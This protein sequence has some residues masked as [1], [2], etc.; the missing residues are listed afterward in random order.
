[1][2]KTCFFLQRNIYLYR[3]K[4]FDNNRLLLRYIFI[5][6]AVVIAIGSLIISHYFVADL[7]KEERNKIKIWAEAT[8]E[9]VRSEENTN[10]NLIIQIL[11]SNTT[12]PVILY[13]EK[14]DFF[15]STNINLPD[16]GDIQ[17][18]LRK[19]SEDFKK[20]NEPIIIEIDDLKQYVY[21]DD[22]HTL[23]RLQLYPYIQLGV[24]GVFVLIAFLALTSTMKM[25][26]D[27]VWVGLSKE[28]AHQLG[29]PISSLLAWIELLRLK[30]TDSTIL[31]DMEKDV[32]RLQVITER[33]SKIGST[34]SFD[35]K[36]IRLV[37]QQSIT[38][39]ERRI[40]KQ[41]VFETNFPDAPLYSLINEALFS[42][43]IENLTK[44]AVDAMGGH[45]C[46]KY[47]L[48]EKDNVIFIDIRDTGKG[49]PKSRFKTVFSPGFTT[50]SRGWGLGLSLTKRIVETYHKGRIY[51]KASE[52]NVGTTFRIELRKFS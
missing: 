26:Q 20:K 12:I 30:N 8:K 16:E 38:Y 43:V 2:N 37:L 40:S 32:S 47:I 33:F 6:V 27:R 51:V 3:M 25:E 46:I 14:D 18:F 13:D 7:S 39:L 4:L 19:K 11:E 22:S 15:M 52:I 50:K 42:W 45:G 5:A 35:K 17:L 49:I 29:T 31:V 23:K 36:D 48:Q 9:A 44:N 21:Y 41:V 1:M 28:T 10:M 24:L 34:P